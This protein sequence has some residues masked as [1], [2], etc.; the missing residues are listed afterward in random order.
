MDLREQR[1]GILPSPAKLP[2]AGTEHGRNVQQQ[3]RFD[4]ACKLSRSDLR[5]IENDKPVPQDTVDASKIIIVDK[6]RQSTTEEMNDLEERFEAWANNRSNRIVDDLFD[7]LKVC[8]G[9]FSATL[10]MRIQ[11]ILDGGCAVR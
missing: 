10:R 2:M 1:K 6:R 5:C 3:Q 7:G 4:S 11:K 8:L 9:Q